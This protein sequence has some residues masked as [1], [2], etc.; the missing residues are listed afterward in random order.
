METATLRKT[1]LISGGVVG[2]LYTALGIFG[3]FWSGHWDEA[4]A[5][6]QIVWVALLM[7]GGVGLLVGLRLLDASPWA[8]AVLVSLGGIL[9][10]MAIFWALIPVLLALAFVVLSVAYARRRA[11]SAA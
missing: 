10:A 6:D 3:I 8:G 1:L 4:S 7:G 2:C 11:A 5:T 9:G